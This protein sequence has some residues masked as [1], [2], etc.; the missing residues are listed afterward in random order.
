VDLSLATKSRELS[1]ESTERAAEAV[2]LGLPPKSCSRKM[3]APAAVIPTAAT[4]MSVVAT[5]A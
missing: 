1:S 5:M 2:A 3:N 4:T